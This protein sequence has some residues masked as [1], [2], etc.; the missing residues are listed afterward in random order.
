MLPS[1]SLNVIRRAKQKPVR[2]SVLYTYIYELRA[3]N[4]KGRK[5]FR[6]GSWITFSCQIQRGKSLFSLEGTFFELR[7]KKFMKSFTYWFWWIFNRFLQ[8]DWKWKIIDL[9]EWNSS[10][11]KWLITLQLSNGIDKV[12]TELF[13]LQIRL[14]RHS[15]W[16]NTQNCKTLD[17]Q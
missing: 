1:H 7:S 16:N 5:G 4:L 3:I 15:K 14:W 11:C 17:N 8:K 13:K 12:Y 6:D 9:L 2:P 10:G